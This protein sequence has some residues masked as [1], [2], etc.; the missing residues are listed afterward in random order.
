MWS[1]CV[2]AAKAAAVV[3]S[4]FSHTYN[5][6]VVFLFDI[7]IVVYYLQFPLPLPSIYY[8]PSLAENKVGQILNF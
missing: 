5:E 7:L 2:V 1:Y 4:T 3:E 8:I 6:V